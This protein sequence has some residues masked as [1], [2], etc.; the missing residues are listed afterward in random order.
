M[1]EKYSVKEAT[2]KPYP[3][4]TSPYYF[5]R[6][7]QNVRK[8]LYFTISWVGIVEVPSVMGGTCNE[9]DEINTEKAK[10]VNEGSDFREGWSF[11]SCQAS[12]GGGTKR[13][14]RRE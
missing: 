6:N 12:G 1:K 10:K 2:F 3:F 8:E 11:G 14:R 5:L 4:K 7:K 13:G 9:L